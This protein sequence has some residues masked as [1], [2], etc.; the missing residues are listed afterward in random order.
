MERDQ[1]RPPRHVH[2]RSDFGSVVGVI[3][4]RLFEGRSKRLKSAFSSLDADCVYSVLIG[5]ENKTEKGG[6]RMGVENKIQG[7]NMAGNMVPDSI[8]METSKREL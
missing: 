2:R 8:M 6:R 5:T 1:S 4:F 7:P 3:F